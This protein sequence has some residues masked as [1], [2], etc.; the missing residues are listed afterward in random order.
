[1]RDKRQP[2]RLTLCKLFSG[3]NRSKVLGIIE[4][5]DPEEPARI[6]ELVEAEV[7]VFKMVHA[8]ERVLQQGTEQDAHSPAMHAD[9]QGMF[10]FHHLPYGWELALLNLERTFSAFNGEIRATQ[11]PLVKYPMVIGIFFGGDPLSFPV[12][13]VDF[14]ESRQDFPGYPLVNKGSY[15]LVG[16]FKGRGK[17]AVEGYMMVMLVEGSG[18]SPSGIVKV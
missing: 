6:A 15:T 1:M 8:A 4:F 11:S 10:M 2:V 12:S 9:E 3:D 16:S 7:F 14:I 13:P 5:F 17:D 18:L